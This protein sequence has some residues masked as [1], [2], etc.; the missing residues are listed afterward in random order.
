MKV[1]TT[2]A[3]LASA[4]AGFDALALVPTMGFLHEGHLSLVRRAKAD[5]GSVAVS[6]FVNPTQF[7]PNE[8]LAS[9][10][11]DLD[12]DLALLAEVGA[13]LVWTPG[14]EDI[15][16]PG[17]STYVDVEGV[18]DVLEGA[19]RPDHFRGVA[20]VVSI[21]FHAV[22]PTAAYFGQKDAQQSVVLRKMVRDQAMAIDLVICPT[23]READG[24][25]M[26]SRNAYLDDAHRAAARVLIRSL[27]EAEAAWRD[28]ETDADALRDRM[29]AVLAAE[30]LAQVGYVSVADPDTLAE[31]DTVEADRGALASLAV[32][33][34][35]PRLIDNLVLPPR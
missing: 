35:K 31:L 17:F 33:V 13:D 15:Y 23:V 20:T 27:R 30:P 9:Y 16:P 29:R 10:P 34:G 25:A 5:H 28:G 22:R 8:D 1:V 6:I 14:V 18:T 4:R 24:L 12:R 21:L 2:R 32:R 26:S 11:R 7:G 19:E 3:E